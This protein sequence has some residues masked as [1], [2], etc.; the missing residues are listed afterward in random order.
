MDHPIRVAFCPLFFSSNGGEFDQN[1]LPRVFR[2]DDE[3]KPKLV[4]RL[5][6]RGKCKKAYDCGS[7]SLMREWVEGEQ[8]RGWVVGWECSQCLKLTKKEA[9]SEGRVLPGF[10]QSGRH[11]DL[12]M[13]DPDYD[14]DKPKLS[15]C[16]RCGYET[17]F[18]Q[19]VLRRR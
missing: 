18:L 13:D 7:C 1:G 3:E 2:V 4:G 6:V 11:P 19:L 9:A 8:R 17:S 14:K 16:T 15:G 5:W 10:Y 12:T